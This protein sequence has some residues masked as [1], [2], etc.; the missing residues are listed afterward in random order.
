V[1][2]E[3]RSKGERI[4]KRGKKKEKGKGREGGGK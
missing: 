3:G 1:K 2:R 4:A